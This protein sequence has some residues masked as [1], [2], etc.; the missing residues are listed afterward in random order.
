MMDPM[1]FERRRTVAV[2][3]LPMFAAVAESTFAPVLPEAPLTAVADHATSRD[4]ADGIVAVAGDLRRRVLAYIVAAGPSG[5]TAAELED[6]PI[7]EPYGASTIRKRVS[8]LARYQPAV[9]RAA[10][11]RGGCTVYVDVH[12][13]E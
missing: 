12:L 11:K 9:V 6:L 10:G 1:L 7:F 3:D 8:E 5:M 4:A 2:D 13:P